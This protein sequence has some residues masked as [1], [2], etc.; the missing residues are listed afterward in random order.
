MPKTDDTIGKRFYIKETTAPEGYKMPLTNAYYV[1]YTK[2]RRVYDVNSTSIPLTIKNIEDNT[3]T[4][5]DLIYTV[6][7]YNDIKVNGVS[8]KYT[9]TEA[10]TAYNAPKTGIIEVYKYDDDSDDSK[11]QGDGLSM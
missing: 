3:T 2:R 1:D 9:E 10:G 8:H 11:S 6:K 5:S 4:T 7:Q